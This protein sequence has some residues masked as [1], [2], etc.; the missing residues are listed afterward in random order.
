TRVDVDGAGSDLALEGLVGADQQLLTGLAAGVERPG[1]LHAT[2]GTVVE[3]S[4]VLAGE[5]DTLGDAL[6]DDVDR[7]LGE[8]V[9]VGLARAE[10]AALDRVVEQPVD[11]VA[12]VAVVLG[13]VDAALSGDRVG[14]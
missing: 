14:A 8:P 3:Q 4:A 7:D 5:G 11:A 10:V 6:V 13:R 1:D 12:V 9:R 2:E